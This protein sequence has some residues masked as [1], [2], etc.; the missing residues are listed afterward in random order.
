MGKRAFYPGMVIVL[1]VFNVL[2]GARIFR[3]KKFEGESVLHGE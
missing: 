3:L 1:G 2:S